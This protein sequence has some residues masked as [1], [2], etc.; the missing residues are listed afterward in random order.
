MSS[1][2]L[3]IYYYGGNI[4]IFNA[5][6]EYVQRLYVRVLNFLKSL[7]KTVEINCVKPTKNFKEFLRTRTQ[8]FSEAFCT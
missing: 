6:F 5:I 8:S 2:Q 1:I 7:R 3:V 4:S